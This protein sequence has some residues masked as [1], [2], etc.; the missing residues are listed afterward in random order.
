MR[1]RLRTRK[2]QDYAFTFLYWIMSRKKLCTYVTG[3]SVDFFSL[4]LI[5]ISLSRGPLALELYIRAS[6]DLFSFTLVLFSVLA[7]YLY[8]QNVDDPREK[9]PLESQE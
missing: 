6:V 9:S 5:S 2:H 4:P 8:R 1:S 3:D 7:I